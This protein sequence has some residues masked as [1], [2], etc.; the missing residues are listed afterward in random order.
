MAAA[1]AAGAESSSP[2]AAEPA[3]A[4]AATGGGAVQ[5]AAAAVVNI[6][7]A[8]ITGL[9]QR[10][11]SLTDG[12]THAIY[13]RLVRSFD[14]FR[15]SGGRR[16]EQ[17]LE[18]GAVAGVGEDVADLLGLRRKA[19]RPTASPDE[20]A[21]EKER[22]EQ[23]AEKKEAEEADEAEEAAAAAEADT[24]DSVGGTSC[25]RAWA[26]R[27][28]MLRT[29]ALRVTFTHP[30][31]LIFT[32]YDPQLSRSM[33]MLVL[34]AT[35][36]VD[37][38]TTAFLY[39]FVTGSSGA[40]ACADAMPPL[41]LVET[42]VVAALSS[43]LQVPL[44]IAIVYLAHSAGASDFAYRYPFVAAEITRRQATEKQLSRLSHE[45]LEAE[46]K[47]VAL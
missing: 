41:T 4:A 6:G 12:Y 43:L 39:A 17:L 45:A 40:D 46:L 16:L 19:A 21:K 44:G 25:A 8:G 27:S 36:I 31:I 22:E 20:V 10:L 38:W 24:L 2:S 9:A 7:A 34:T 42:V 18:S 15:V 14:P 37:L 29:W 3:L 30:Y 5:A 13:K 35:L 32:K 33:R 47:L 26:L 23:A 28:F 1:A 11:S